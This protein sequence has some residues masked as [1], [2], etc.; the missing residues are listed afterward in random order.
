[1]HPTL[2]DYETRTIGLDELT[3]LLIRFA[4]IAA[5]VVV[6]AVALFGVAVHLKRRGKWDGTKQRIG[7]LAVRA[8]AKRLDEGRDRS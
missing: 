1:M 8:A 2:L 3:L 6:V 4:I 7:P 5:V